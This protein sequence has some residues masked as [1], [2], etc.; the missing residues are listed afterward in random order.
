ALRAVLV[1]HVEQHEAARL[2]LL[3]PGHARRFLL[4]GVLR[5]LVGVHRLAACRLA[6][7]R[8]LFE[9]LLLFLLLLRFGS[10]TVG[11]LLV[12]IGFE[13]PLLSFLSSRS[14]LFGPPWFRAPR[15]GGCRN[16]RALL[17]GLLGQAKLAKPCRLQRQRLVLAL[18]LEL[19]IGFALL[20]LVEE[21]L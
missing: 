7:R 3:S 2:C 6:L 9:T 10:V 13:S 19:E 16:R 12:V 8:L 4:L 11:A 20:R 18:L 5:T 21:S 14:G 17:G 15:R 1:D